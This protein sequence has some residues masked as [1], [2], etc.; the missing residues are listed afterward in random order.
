[1]EIGW[2]VDKGVDALKTSYQIWKAFRDP[3]SNAPRQYR[4]LA[5][6]FN[7]CPR[8]GNTDTIANIARLFILYLRSI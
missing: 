3:D 7:V 4:D 5:G 8:K 2:A 6:E 1:M